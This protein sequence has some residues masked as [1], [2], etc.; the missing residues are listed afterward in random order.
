MEISRRRLIG[1]AALGAAAALIGPAWR[2]GRADAM[3]SQVFDWL[4]SRPV[5]APR[6]GEDILDFAARVLPEVTPNDAF[7]VQSIGLPPGG[8]SPAD[9]PIRISGD[10]RA[11]LDLSVSELSR[12]PQ[13]EAWATLTCIGNPVS[14]GQIGNALWRGV[15]L[16]ALLERAGAGRRTLSSV[17]GK[18]IFRAADGYHDSIPIE[19]AMDERTLICLSMNGAPLPA[20]HGAPL[21]LLVPGVYGLKCVKWIQSIE[22]APEGHAGYWQGRGWSDTARVETLS[23]FEAPRRRVTVGARSAWLIGSA[24]AG[25]RGIGRVEVSYGLGENKRPW[26]PALLKKPLGPLAWTPWAFR[27]DFPEEGFYPATVRATDGAGQPQRVKI[28]APKPGGATGLMELNLY[29]KGTGGK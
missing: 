22:V 12:M 1:G 18:V 15:P 27:M 2:P 10:V 28:S 7:Y 20:A 21:R 25:E 17:A 24:F 3:L 6:P 13:A 5:E 9:W 16:R 8:G 23:R 19:A 11:Q 4:N 26:A 14:G 29:V